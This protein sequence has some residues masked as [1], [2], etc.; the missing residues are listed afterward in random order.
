MVEKDIAKEIKKLVGTKNLVT[1]TKE[2]IKHLKKGTAKQ[3]VLSSNCPKEVRDDV[4]HY[5]KIGGVLVVETDKTN[6]EM[7]V[8]CK[9]Q[10]PVSV[11]SII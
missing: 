4:A 11:L 3:V 10:H 1:G 5:A 7:G 2:S 6:L 8:L 9:K